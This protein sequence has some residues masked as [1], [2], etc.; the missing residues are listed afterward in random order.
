MPGKRNGL[1]IAIAV[2]LLELIAGMQTYLSQLILPIMAAEFGSQD[3]YG[4]VMGVASVASMVGLPVGAA[5]LQRF[6]LP[7]LLLV[8]TAFLCAGAIISATSP[9]I[10]IYL[11]GQ[12]VRGFSASCLAM[13]SL[14]AV[15]L[16]LS[17]RAR[18]LTLAFSSASWVVASIVGPTY[19]A[20][21]TQLFSWRWAMLI[22]LP[23]LIAARFVVALNLD[24][25]Q[26][27]RKAPIPFAQVLVLSVA[28]TL[29]VL[30]VAGALRG[31]C[32]AGGV[33]LLLQASVVLLPRGTFT[34]RAPRKRALAGM[35]FLTGAYF[36]ANELVG[37][38]AHDL[39]HAQAGTLGWILLAGGLTWAV[40][41]VLCGI[42]PAGSP[43]SYRLRSGVG[44]ALIALGAAAMAG[45]CIGISG[46][47]SAATMILI[48]W[49]V[50]GLG[51]GATY[52]DTLSIFFDEPAV[53]D[54]ISMEQIAGASVMVESLSQAMFVPLTASTVAMG[55]SDGEPNATFYGLAWLFVLAGSVAAW[56]Y[57]HTTGPRIGADAR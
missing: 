51:M 35:F 49:A 3:Y 50:C 45:M 2:I 1:L 41:G 16:G 22:Y 47:G 39:Y 12:F 17:G 33:A 9:N 4:L 57:L 23:L 29:T 34:A 18:Q 5:L 13:A 43:R 27:T 44:V 21:A 24:R 48:L 11:I 14:G 38:T 53:D 15:A 36:A 40:M 26:M 19:A 10:G 28:V 6:R 7:R 56:V 32:I 52:V 30:P 55:F 20:W 46:T 25:K 54:G 42:R 37:L 31:L 8:L